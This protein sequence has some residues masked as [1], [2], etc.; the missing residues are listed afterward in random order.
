MRVVLLLELENVTDYGQSIN[1]EN[2][3]RLVIILNDVRGSLIDFQE[4]GIM[5]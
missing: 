1:A 2:I 3:H 4:S 5:R